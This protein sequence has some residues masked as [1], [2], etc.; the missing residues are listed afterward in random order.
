MYVLFP[1]NAH[2]IL[3]FDMGFSSFVGNLFFGFGEIYSFVVGATIICGGIYYRKRQFDRLGPVGFY[4]NQVAW[5]K[6]VYGTDAS[7]TTKTRLKLSK[8]HESLGQKVQALAVMEELLAQNPRVNMEMAGS[9]YRFRMGQLQYDAGRYH[10]ALTSFTTA[11]R[12]SRNQNPQDPQRTLAK[13]RAIRWH[14]FGAAMERV[15]QCHEKLGNYDDTI[16]TYE[17]VIEVYKNYGFTDCVETAKYYI[18]LARTH[19]R[20]GNNTRAKTACQEALRIYFLNHG[21]YPSSVTVAELYTQLADLHERGGELTKALEYYNNA[22][23]VYCRSGRSNED[24]VVTKLRQTV[25]ELEM[26]T[27]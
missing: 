20:A 19:E 12:L 2:R 11:A 9:F 8:A 15:A 25:S 24:T 7:I 6:K 4:K 16:R 18:Y 10:D 27:C 13:R 21:E 22:I 26:R 3:K 5:Y 14:K 23:D 1:S 17:Q